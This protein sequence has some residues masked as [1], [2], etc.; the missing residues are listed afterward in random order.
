MS[1]HTVLIQR[2]TGSVF[3]AANNTQFPHSYGVI[4]V[5]EFDNISGGVAF[6]YT[7]QWSGSVSVIRVANHWLPSNVVVSLA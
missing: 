3:C 2:L 6:F 7:G 1:S 5:S 4:T